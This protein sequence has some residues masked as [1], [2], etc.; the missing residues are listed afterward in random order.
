MYGGTALEFQVERGAYHG[1]GTPHEQ[2]QFLVVGKAFG[3][4]V[5]QRLVGNADKILYETLL[6]YPGWLRF[7][8]L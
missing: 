8:R 7:H 2:G 4:Y 5:L 1:N 3:V 6:W